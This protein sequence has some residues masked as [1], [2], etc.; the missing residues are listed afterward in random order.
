M[1][2]VMELV[3]PGRKICRYDNGD[4]PPRWKLPF[5]EISGYQPSGIAL[6]PVHKEVIFAAAAQIIEDYLPPSGIMNAVVTFSW[7]E[8]F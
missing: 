3:E 2:P 8:I 6:D 5:R 7:P 4:V 1:A